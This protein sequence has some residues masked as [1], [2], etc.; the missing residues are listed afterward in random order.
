MYIY[1]NIYTYIHIYWYS[2]LLITS[3]ACNKVPFHDHVVYRA[4]HA[5][6]FIYV[7]ICIIYTYISIYLYM[8]VFYFE[9]PCMVNLF[10]YRKL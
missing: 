8:Y 7:Y 10:L 3:D 2:V 6:L 4:L 1:I 9:S 5:F